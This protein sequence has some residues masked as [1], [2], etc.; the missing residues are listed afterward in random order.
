MQFEDGVLMTLLLTEISSTSIKIDEL[1]S[2]YSHV[3][4]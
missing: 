2:D 4:Q 3:K 1:L